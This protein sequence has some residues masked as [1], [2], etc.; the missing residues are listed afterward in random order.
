M[1]ECAQ[2]I[3]LA[4]HII[5]GTFVLNFEISRIHISVWGIDRLSSK[6][7]MDAVAGALMTLVNSGCLGAILYAR[8]ILGR[9]NE[10]MSKCISCI[11][12]RCKRV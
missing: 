6:H 11:T 10:L 7:W 2:F 3:G 12:G 4:V 5:T 8:Q 1:A 9:G